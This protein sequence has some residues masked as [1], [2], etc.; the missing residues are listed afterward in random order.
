MNSPILNQWPGISDTDFSRR[1][2]TGI[3]IINWFIN[4]CPLPV[5]E[6][7]GFDRRM[8]QNF[9]DQIVL[10]ESASVSLSWSD[11]NGVEWE[12]INV[13]LFSMNFIWG[14]RDFPNHLFRFCHTQW[15][16]IQII[17]MWFHHS[18]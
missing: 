12:T 7:F 8:Q 1:I 13:H 6:K 10:I 3:S 2:F 9:N 4:G 17:L 16:T 5:N 14:F 18:D 15:M 11:A